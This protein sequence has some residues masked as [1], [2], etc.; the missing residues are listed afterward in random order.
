MYLARFDY[1]YTDKI[2][3]KIVAM[4]KSVDGYSVN[5]LSFKAVN[6]EG[7]TILLKYDKDMFEEIEEMATEELLEDYYHP[8]FYGAH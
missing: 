1:H 6:D 5:G 2:C 7:K 8:P 3:Y 4:C